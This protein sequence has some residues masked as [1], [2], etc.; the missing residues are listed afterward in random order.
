M[1]IFNII[2]ILSI[3]GK[4]L[5]NFGTFR[6]SKKKKKIDYNWVTIAYGDKNQTIF[7]IITANKQVNYS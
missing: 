7:R 6:P 2:V 4:E 5:F 1:K 3:S